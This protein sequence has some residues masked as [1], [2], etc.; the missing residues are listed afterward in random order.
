MLPPLQLRHSYTCKR[1][2]GRGRPPSITTTTSRS[3]YFHHRH[4]Q[5]FHTHPHTARNP[6][7][8]SLSAAPGAVFDMGAAV[9]VAEPEWSGAHKGLCLYLS[10]LLQVCCAALR[11]AA[12]CLLRVLRHAAVCCPLAA[13][14]ACW[15]LPCL[16]CAVRV[17]AAWQHCITLRPSCCAMLCHFVQGVWEDIIVGPARGAPSVLQC[18]IPTAALQVGS[19]PPPSL[20][21]LPACTGVVQL[22]PLCNLGQG[23]ARFLRCGVL[24]SLCVVA[25]CA[26]APCRTVR[27]PSSTVHRLS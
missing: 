13:L 21:P 3:H 18:K 26:P 1:P 7:A 25:R 9:P 27:P 23:T 17:R 6:P 14:V 16:L 20:P 5:T 4:H 10:R 19:L 15:V 11:R 2:Q 24:H 12:L 8:P 22:P